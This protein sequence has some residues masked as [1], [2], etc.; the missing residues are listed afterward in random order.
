MKVTVFAPF[1]PKEITNVI[2]IE[3][4][5]YVI[6]VDG[7]FDELIK[8]KIKIDLV[9]GDLDSIKDQRKLKSYEVK[10][11]NTVKD[12][13]DTFEAIKIAYQKSNNVFLIGG[14]KGNRI[15]HLLANLTLFETA[16]N[17]IIKDENS[18]IYR[19][20]SG[21]HLIKKGGYISFFT[22]GKAIITLEGFK[23]PLT[24]Y[25]L[26]ANDPL[27]ISNEIEKLYGEV[28]IKEGSLLVIETKK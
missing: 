18:Q 2:T 16:N 9:V 15:E 11:L 6:A 5:D 13:T 21:K 23:Y 7:A 27:C 28:I 24:D 26:K 14:I 8:Q 1:V 10:K 20:N 17:L 4:D 25:V 3:S 19:L 12:T 22:F